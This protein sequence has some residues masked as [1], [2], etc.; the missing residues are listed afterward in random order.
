MATGKWKRCR[1]KVN[2]PVRGKLASTRQP[3]DGEFD[4]R[5]LTLAWGWAGN[6]MLTSRRLPGR[7]PSSALGSP[8]WLGSGQHICQSTFIYHV[9]PRSRFCFRMWNLCQSIG[10]GAQAH[11]RGSQLAAGE[12]TRLNICFVRLTLQPGQDRR[13]FEL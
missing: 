12:S 4:P 7:D 5:L 11:R 2:K 6:Q 13:S 9:V 8:L 10:A 3:R 1:I